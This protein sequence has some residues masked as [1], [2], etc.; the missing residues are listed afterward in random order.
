[1]LPI[2]GLSGKGRKRAIVRYLVSG[3]FVG[4]TGSF[5]W[6]SSNITNTASDKNIRSG[7]IIPS[8]KDF[9]FYLE[10][11]ASAAGFNCGIA[12]S[13][14][15]TGVAQP[16]NTNPIV[17]AKSQ[18]TGPGWNNNNGSVEAAR[19]SGWCANKVIGLHRRGSVLSGS[20][21]FVS[22]FTSAVSTTA[23]ML[24]FFG[25]GGSG[26]GWSSDNNR[27]VLY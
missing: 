16:T 6:S 4:D 2:G 21:D 1:M 14:S 25:C 15:S 13:G 9:D 10:V 7:L 5:S 23:A 12:T 18:G 27:L 26:S 22:D 8:N 11:N 20:I 24:V 17:Y 3:D 19:T